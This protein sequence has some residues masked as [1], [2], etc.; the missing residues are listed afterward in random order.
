MVLYKRRDM[1]AGLSLKI[2]M[3]FSKVGLSPNQWTF[4]TI[5]PTLIAVYFLMENQ[6]LMAALFFI[7]SAFIDLVDGSVARVMGKVSKLGAYFDTIMDRYV[8]GIILFGLL[9]VG[10][11]DFYISA[12][13]WIVLYLIGSFMTTYAKSAA[14]EK[15]LTVDEIKGGLL[16][17][18]ER[19]IILFVGILLAYYSTLYLTYIIVLLAVLTN[20]TA[21]QRIKIATKKR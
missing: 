4:I 19:L 13:A 1:F 2:G 15:N 17:R 9:F 6:F 12:S 5:I 21:L 16:E 8:E 20:I 7:V 10:L 11:P 3:V 18:A 14:K